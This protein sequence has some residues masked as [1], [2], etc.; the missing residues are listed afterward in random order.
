MAGFVGNIKSL[1][2]ELGN[3]VFD[4]TINKEINKAIKNDGDPTNGSLWKYEGEIIVYD[5]DKHLKNYKEYL[6]FILKENYIR[7]LEELGRDAITNIICENIKSYLDNFQQKI[8]DLFTNKIIETVLNKTMNKTKIQKGGMNETITSLA[9]AASTS[10][11]SG[12][13]VI[14][15]PALEKSY[16]LKDAQQKIKAQKDTI[17]KNHVLYPDFLN[18]I[19]N[20]IETMFSGKPEERFSGKPEE[21]IDTNSVANEIARVDASVKAYVKKIGSKQP[22]LQT[23]GDGDSTSVT[24][25]PET[26]SVTSNLNDLPDLYTISPE[27][28]DNNKITT[29]ITER[30]FTLLNEKID[31]KRI[32]EE[33]NP[34]FLYKMWEFVFHH[35]VMEKLIAKE[36]HIKFIP[37]IL[38]PHNYI[39]KLTY[40]YDLLFG[41]N[42]ST[43]ILQEISKNMDDK[44]KEL[45]ESSNS[46]VDDSVIKLG[47]SPIKLND[48]IKELFV[49]SSVDISPPKLDSSLENPYKDENFVVSDFTD[50][51]IKELLDFK[52][53]PNN[54]DNSV[55]FKNKSI[56]KELSAD[57]DKPELVPTV[58]TKVSNIF[59]TMVEDSL[60]D[61]KSVVKSS[62]DTH[63]KTLADWAISNIDFCF[64]YAIFTDKIVMSFLQGVILE[65][66]NIYKKYLASTS[67]LGE[68]QNLD[69]ILVSP[70]NRKLFK[71]FVLYGIY[72]SIHKYVLNSYKFY[73][74]EINH[75]KKLTEDSN[76][77]TEDSGTTFYVNINYGNPNNW[78]NFVTLL[79]E[80][81][82]TY[83]DTDTDIESIH[84]KITTMIEYA[85][86]TETAPP[87]KGG[88]K[89]TRRTNPK[90]YTSKRREYK[91]KYT[92]YRK[93]N[94]TLKRRYKKS[95]K[96]NRR[97]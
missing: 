59:K 19:T 55:I 84:K 57:P 40:L 20:K 13:I 53:D 47:L 5:K 68:S 64:H 36:V 33:L 48:I 86:T 88:S 74:S 49:S 11:F 12:P 69:E 21:K 9:Q 43:I 41:E 80:I 67:T 44:I 23:G 91:K 50:G 32:K 87:T 73:P 93:I 3:T 56:Y 71:F 30:V 4:N 22:A 42:R 8:S 72:F 77:F 1:S 60:V 25:G 46:T 27:T 35:S 79:R 95:G 14:E 54:P 6:D 76:P 31:T 58:E 89:K 82:P 90:K 97:T 65:C 70:E 92:Q 7:P 28:L 83:T 75:K 45:I 39:D 94:K 78:N 81:D 63:V 62:L 29:Y 10:A 15:P 26:T 16:I 85:K 24:P 61:F 18:I 34:V 38:K 2:S 96:K 52:Y 37:N 17:T 51:P 66:F